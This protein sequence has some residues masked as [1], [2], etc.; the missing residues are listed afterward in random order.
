MFLLFAFPIKSMCKLLNVPF[1]AMLII[2]NIISWIITKVHQ[3]RKG[4]NFNT[5]LLYFLFIF[6]VKLVVMSFTTL[7]GYPLIVLIFSEVPSLFFIIFMWENFKVIFIPKE[8][9]L[10]LY[11]LQANNGQSLEDNQNITTQ[12]SSIHN[13]YISDSDSVRSEDSSLTENERLENRLN[14]IEDKLVSTD[15]SIIQLDKIIKERTRLN[16]RYFVLS[17]IIRYIEPNSSVALSQV[18]TEASLEKK[19]EENTRNLIESRR[20]FHELLTERLNVLDRLEK[21]NQ[22]NNN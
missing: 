18:F 15:K 2:S 7:Y 14:K 12:G 11:F 3:F 9:P 1:W 4:K 20:K 22:D 13:S 17:K 21:N 16:H 5:N 6:F 19:I 8:P 10:P